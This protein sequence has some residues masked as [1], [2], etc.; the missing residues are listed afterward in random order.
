MSQTAITFAFEQWKAQ[1]AAAGNTVVLDEFVLAY[2]PGLDHTA[3]INRTETLPPE[4]QIVHRQAVNKIG[5]VNDNA[6]VYSVTMGTEIGDFDFN[7]IGLVNKA[8]GTV[9]MIVH[10]P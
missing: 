10:A 7:W 5:L 1:E 3:P 2:V 8:S 4:A 6:V 9:A